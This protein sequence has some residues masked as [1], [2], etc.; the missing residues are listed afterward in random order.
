MKKYVHLYQQVEIY[1]FAW[2]K[3]VLYFAIIQ[4]NVQS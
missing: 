3:G 2:E 1:R 4:V